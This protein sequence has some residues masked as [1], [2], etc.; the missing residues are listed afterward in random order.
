MDAFMAAAL[1][2]AQAGFEEGGSPIGAVLVK[3]G[4][5]LGRGRNVLMQ[6]GDPTGHAEMEAYRDAARRAAATH[7]PEEIEGL[8]RG[9]V[10]YTTMMPCEMCAG[11]IVRF[12]ASRVVVGETTTYVESGTRLLM[13]RRGI[14]V[15]VLQS[16]ESIP[17]IELY[18]PRQPERRAA[19]TQRATPASRTRP[20]HPS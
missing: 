9:G 20:P 3:D 5:I 19:M 18:L 10:M 14:E 7:A 13:E 8:L 15:S 6:R 2:E 12:S 17:H 11:A 4:E 1:A 16:V